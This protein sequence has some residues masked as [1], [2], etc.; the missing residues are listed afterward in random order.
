MP[1]DGL[2]GPA[3]YG[4]FYWCVKVS[5]EISPD[6]EIYAYASEV[7]TN[8]DGSLWLI[9]KEAHPNLVLPS[10]KWLA[11]YGASVMDGSA[12]AVEHWKGEVVR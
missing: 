2:T 7:K 5:E 11:C 6:G 10:G 4:R 12:V 1:N 9:G 8:Q 3:K